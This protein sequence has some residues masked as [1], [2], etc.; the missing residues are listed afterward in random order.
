[1]S[2]SPLTSSQDSLPGKRQLSS[3]FLALASSRLER[4]GTTEMPG[5]PVIRAGR[6]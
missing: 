4:S 5:P 3:L 2:L 6:K 1:M